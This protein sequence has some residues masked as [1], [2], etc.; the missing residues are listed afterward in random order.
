MVESTRQVQTR[1]PFDRFDEAIND[2]RL[3]ETYERTELAPYGQAAV[4]TL[5][6]AASLVGRQL[7]LE[8]V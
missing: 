3:Y 2:P 6:R 7:H 1:D 4:E 8:L 5:Q